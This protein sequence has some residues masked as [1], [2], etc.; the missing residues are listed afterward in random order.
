MSKR[1]LILGASSLQIPIIEKAKRMGLHVGVIDMDPEAPGRSL[2]DVFFQISTYDEEKV[3]ECARNFRPDGAVTGAT[4]WPVRSVARINEELGLAGIKYET[5]RKCTEKDLMA[6]A[7]EK[8]N[9]PIPKFAVLSLLKESQSAVEEFINSWEIYPCIAKPTDSSG[10]RGVNIVLNKEQLLNGLKYSA[11]SSRSKTVIIQEYLD[12]DEVSVEGF[13][14]NGDFKVIQVTDKITSG[15]PYFVELGHIQPSQLS[16]SK[17]ADCREIAVFAARALN[18]TDGA[19]HAELKVDPLTSKAKIIEFGARLGG[20]N[21]GTVLTEYSTGFDIVSAVIR[22]SL[23]ETVRVPDELMR[24]PICIKYLFPDSKI[25]I[26]KENIYSAM[27]LPKVIGVS[28]TNSSTSASVGCFSSSDRLANVIASGV[29]T[30]EA[31][32][33]AD[34]A[35]SRLI[36]E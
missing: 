16:P 20:D 30:D 29:T 4:D 9:V 18:M 23:G 19:F 26:K 5:A 6:I 8:G 24:N 2:A 13:V 11:R 21:I 31:L 10:S 28:V 27:N 1:L 36:G 14:Q 22:N 15:A 33:I 12:G 35:I 34:T 17:L 32:K 25:E 3:L 7:L